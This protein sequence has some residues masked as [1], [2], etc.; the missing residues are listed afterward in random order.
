MFIDVLGNKRRQGTGEGKRCKFGLAG[1]CVVNGGLTFC[2]V[3]SLCL[4]LK[5]GSIDGQCCKIIRR[6]RGSKFTKV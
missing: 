6:K 3:G 2:P 1:Y 4:P 5:S